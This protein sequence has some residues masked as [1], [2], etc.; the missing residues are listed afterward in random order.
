VREIARVEGPAG[1][2]RGLSAGIAQIVPYMGL[3]FA[4]YEGFKPVCVELGESMPVTGLGSGEAAA[5]VLASLMA[6]TVVFPLDTVRKRFQVQGP[7]LK[8]YGSAMRVPDYGKGVV[9]TII[10]I[11]RREGFRG[12]YRGLPVSLVKAAPASAVTVWTYERTMGLLRSVEG[13]D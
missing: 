13:E 8:R 4:L 6:K 10:M 12:L 5:G 9:G 3:F 2:F 1:F 7:M 11:A